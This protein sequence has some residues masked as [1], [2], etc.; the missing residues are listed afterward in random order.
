M[1]RWVIVVSTMAATLSGA[2][3]MSQ[4][5]QVQESA[6][7]SFQ[8]AIEELRVSRIPSQT[9]FHVPW[10]CKEREPSITA[11]QYLAFYV[12]FHKTFS[13]VPVPPDCRIIEGLKRPFLRMSMPAYWGCIATI[14]APSTS[15]IDVIVFPDCSIHEY[16]FELLVRL[17]LDEGAFS[18]SDIAVNKA[19]INILQ[20]DLP[21]GAYVPSETEVIIKRKANG[22]LIIKAPV[23]FS[24]DN[25]VRYC[26]MVIKPNGRIRALSPRFVPQ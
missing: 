8:I 10:V 14:P 18:A 12:C 7:A 1:R 22:R 9:T 3:I 17:F 5:H 24:Y 19:V 13:V 11:L 2:S 26:K 4:Q 23:L 21:G 16:S 15:V 20:A 6:T 25:R